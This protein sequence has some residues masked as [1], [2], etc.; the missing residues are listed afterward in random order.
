MTVAVVLLEQGEDVMP[1]PLR[2]G[3]KRRAGSDYE[4]VWRSGILKRH[5]SHIPFVARNAA[6]GC[7]FETNPEI[8]WPAA[9]IAAI[10]SVATPLNQIDKPFNRLVGLHLIAW[11]QVLRL[12][13]CTEP[14]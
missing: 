14:L 8:G 7:P 12:S 11:V 13:P 2:A 5:P 9:L 3:C 10:R 1:Q 6:C 4:N